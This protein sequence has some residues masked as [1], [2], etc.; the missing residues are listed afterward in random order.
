MRLSPSRP[1]GRH[2]PLLLLLV[3]GSA[4]AQVYRQVDKNGVVTYTDQPPS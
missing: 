3:A 4:M 2:L 1:N